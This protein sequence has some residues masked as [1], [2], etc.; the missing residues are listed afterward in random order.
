MIMAAALAAPL[1]AVQLSDL[2]PAMTRNQA[3]DELTKDYAYRILSDL[4]VRRIWNL[5]A[6]RKLSVDFDPK[7]D[8]LLYVLVEYKKP[9]AVKDG[10]EDAAAMTHAEKVKWKKLDVKKAVK[11]AVE[12]ARVSKVGDAYLFLE[13]NSS[14][15]CVRVAMYTDAPKENRRHLNALVMGSSGATALGNNAR[16]DAGRELKADEAARQARANKTDVAGGTPQEAE[17]EDFGVS[18]APKT[19]P[20]ASAAAAPTAEAAFENP[21]EVGVPQP[22]PN[23][24]SKKLQTALDKAGLGEVT[25]TQWGIGAVALVLLLTIIGMV[26]RS[27]EAK[28]LRAKARAMS[29]SDPGATLR[30]R[31]GL[32]KPRVRR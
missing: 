26:R 12:N 18:A 13:C 4:T 1:G 20:T 2:N 28:R 7:K 27:N 15:K 8:K 16:A 17:E 24:A 11:Y 21:G 3:D 19:S 23:V 25:P 30:A 32:G 29:K 9:V 6:N 22:P 31:S 5:D 10:M 14:G